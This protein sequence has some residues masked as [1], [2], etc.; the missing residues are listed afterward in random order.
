LA[1]KSELQSDSIAPIVETESEETDQEQP[2]HDENAVDDHSW[3]QPPS[4]RDIV[5]LLMTRRM[6]R[7]RT[8]TQISRST[9]QVSVFEANGSVRSIIYWVKKAR[10]DRGQRRAFEI[11]VATFIL[12]F[13]IGA[14]QPTESRVRGQRHSFITEKK[15]L[16]L[17]ADVRKRKSDQLICLLHGPGGSGKTA[18]IDLLM[19]YAWEYCSYLEHFEFT[20]RTIVVTAMTG[21]AATILLGQTTHSAV[22]LN[23]RRPLE[24]KQV[25]LWTPT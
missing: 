10:L 7:R 18:V 15:R 6:R 14:P 1:D 19:E 17:L 9:E 2:P 8:F 23:Q 4:Q 16:Q 11:M 13:Y 25:E 22:Y 24:A 21:V 5:T 3:V 12:T 20:S